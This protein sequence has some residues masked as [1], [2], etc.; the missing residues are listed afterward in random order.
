L[1]RTGSG[2]RGGRDYRW[3]WGDDW[4]F[5]DWS[6]G[7]LLAP[8]SRPYVVLYK[9]KPLTS[10]RSGRVRRFATKEAAARAAER[11]YRVSGVPS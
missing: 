10:S 3:N 6:I 9:R 11:H 1:S 8:E 5:G 2:S 7:R 4:K